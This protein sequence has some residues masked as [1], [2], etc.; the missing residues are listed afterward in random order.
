MNEAEIRRVVREVLL[1][2][3]EQH[4]DRLDDVVLK[5]ISAILTGFGIHE[6][7]RKEIAE[8]FRYLRRWRQGAER[9]SSVGMTALVTLIVG[10]IASA[11]WIGIKFML[12]KPL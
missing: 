2:E 6:D 7:E 11:C 10:G 1:E 3:R 8:D 4:N 9:V 5:T 12:G